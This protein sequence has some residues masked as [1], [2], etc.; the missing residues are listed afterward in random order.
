M[1]IKK[2]LDLSFNTPNRE[3][4]NPRRMYGE[5]IYITQGMR[6]ISYFLYV[7]EISF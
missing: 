2:N 3:I 1:K 6:R 4:Y 7:H 5:Q